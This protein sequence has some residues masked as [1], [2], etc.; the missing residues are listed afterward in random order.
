MIKIIIFIFISISSI[1]SEYIIN[2]NLEQDNWIRD[3]DLEIVKD[4]VNNIMWQDNSEAKTINKDWKG[5]IDYCKNLDLGGFYNWRLPTINE[6]NSII[7][8][9]TTN[10]AI[11]NKFKNISQYIYYWSSTSY[12][13]NKAWLI[14]FDYGDSHYRNYENNHSIRCV[15]RAYFLKKIEPKSVIEDISSWARST[16]DETL[17]RTRLTVRTIWEEVQNRKRVALVIGISNYSQERNDLNYLASPQKD[18]KDIYEYLK[19]TLKFDKVILLIDNNATSQKIKDRIA[20]LNDI[21]TRS[22][23]DILIYYS[24]H[25]T[26]FNNNACLVPIDA[27]VN[28][29]SRLLKLQSDIIENVITNKFRHKLF[30]FDSCYSGNIRASLN[31]SYMSPKSS[32]DIKYEA[33]NKDVLKRNVIEKMYNTGVHILTSSSANQLSYSSEDRWNG[34]SLFTYYLLKATRDKKADISNDGVI[35]LP[36]LYLY[37]DDSI[38]KKYQAPTLK[39]YPSDMSYLGE[40]MFYKK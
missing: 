29:G 5:A 7:D 19:Y 40:F 33:R 18:A 39:A 21:S 36:E 15:R 35:T 4:T 25:G 26:K 22:N 3:N 24:G 17:E 8:Y 14:G 30:I 32:N 10:P 38:P 2:N 6:L 13:K 37:L 28:S 9:N 12:D 34:N 1:N 27:K 16:L 20:E 11:K 23:S 31:L